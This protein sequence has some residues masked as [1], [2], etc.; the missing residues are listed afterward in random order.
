MRTVSLGDLIVSERGLGCVGMSSLYGPADWDA[1]IA[2]IRR[3]IDLG[4]T[5]IDTA[6]VYGFGHNEVLV[7]RG[8]AGWRDK[9]QLATK[10]GMDP[11]AGFGVTRGDP[12]FIRGAC[13]RSMR[14]LGVEVIDLLYLHR[15]SSNT[16]IEE[17]VGAMA[18]LV[19]EGMVRHIGLCEVNGDQLRAAHA[20]HAIAAVQS[21]YSLWTRDPETVV[22]DAARE[23]G[24]GLVAYSPLGSGFLTGTVDPRALG[25]RDGRRLIPRFVGHAADAN[26]LVADAIGEIAQAKGITSAQV[27][28]A[29][30][31][32]QSTRLDVQVVP[33]P[34]AKHV[35]WVEENATVIDVRFTPAELATLDSLAAQ[36]I[37]DRRPGLR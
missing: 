17:S 5:L 37:G 34:G 24:V 13:I 12:E 8:I 15:V 1:S 16:P 9:V 4:M 27:A 30:L 29:W 2:A 28:L 20:A 32:Q 36:V 14:R 22:V 26:R 18:K 31:S 3:A 10:V 7:G 21:E 25:G 19:T 35:K 23:L 11:S 33:I 6:D